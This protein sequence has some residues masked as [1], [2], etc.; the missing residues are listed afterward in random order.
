[1]DISNRDDGN[2]ILFTFLTM[3][4]YRLNKVNVPI[5]SYNDWMLLKKT[6]LSPILFVEKY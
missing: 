4:A 1:M 3:P 5:Q 2:K 6:E